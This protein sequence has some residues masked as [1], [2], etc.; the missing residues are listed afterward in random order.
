MTRGRLR[1]VTEAIALDLKSG[2]TLPEAVNRRKTDL[3]TFYGNPSRQ[4]CARAGCP[5]CWPRS[6][7]Y[8]RTVATTRAIVI[9]AMFYPAVV[10]VFALAL[11]VG[12]VFLYCRKFDSAFPGIRLAL[13]L[14]TRIFLAA[15]RYPLYVI[16]PAVGILLGLFVLWEALRSTPRGNFILAHVVYAVPVLG[17]LIRSA[18]LGGVRGPLALLVE[19][20]LPLPGRFRLAGDASSDPIMARQAHEIQHWLDQGVALGSALRGRGL[21]PEWVAW[22]T[23]A[24]EQRGRCPDAAA[25]RR[26]VPSAGR[27]ASHA[28]TERAAGVHDHHYGRRADGRLHLHG[29]AADDRP[30]RWNEV[31]PTIHGYRHRSPAI[32]HVCVGQPVRV[33]LR[34]EVARYHQ[35]L[36]AAIAGN[37]FRFVAASYVVATYGWPLAVPLFLFICL[38]V[39]WIAFTYHGYC[40]ARRKRSC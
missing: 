15:G 32:P 29:H 25:D 38:A 40:Q 4:A 17:T 11:S 28:A 22:M 1:R 7:T 31:G 35:D 33:L 26:P 23:G 3:P 10:L 24:G 2:T 27:G 6:T 14:P 20:E 5:T 9:D 18:R 19:Y 37:V 30:D 8:A 36:L 12:L 34:T 21:L 39:V 16:L 13:P